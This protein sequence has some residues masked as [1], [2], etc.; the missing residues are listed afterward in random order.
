MEQ[1]RRLA[2]RAFSLPDVSLSVV[3]N[4]FRNGLGAAVAYLTV[5]LARLHVICSCSL[6]GQHRDWLAYGFLVSNWPM[7]FLLW[8]GLILHILRA[9][10]Q[11]FLTF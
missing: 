6:I 9:G 5:Y 2:S 4:I 7:M 1:D 10:N 11:D 8:C 3:D